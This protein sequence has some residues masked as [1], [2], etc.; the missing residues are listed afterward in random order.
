MTGLKFVAAIFLLPTFPKF[1]PTPETLLWTVYPYTQGGGK[2][3]QTRNT[4]QTYMSRG[5]FLT[6]ME[7]VGVQGAGNEM[8]TSPNRSI[9]QHC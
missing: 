8:G 4:V 7:G 1:N 2:C 5:T 9:R 3:L 6:A